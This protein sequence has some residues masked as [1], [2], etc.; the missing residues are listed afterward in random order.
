MTSDFTGR[1]SLDVD[2][3]SQLATNCLAAGDWYRAREFA[4]EGIRLSANDPLLLRTLAY[5]ECELGET[6]RAAETSA[7]ALAHEPGDVQNYIVRSHCLLAQATH[8]I[9][10]LDVHGYAMSAARITRDGL[11]LDPNNVVLRRIRAKSLA[12]GGEWR[13]AYLELH[14]VIRRSPSDLDTWRAASV[15]GIWTRNWRATIESCRRGLALS[16]N[17]P[18]LQNNLAVALRNSGQSRA[19]ADIFLEQVSR[20]PHSSVARYN[21]S[22]TGARVLYFIILLA[23]AGVFL[24]L[25]VPPTAAILPC[26]FLYGVIARSPVLLRRME[27]VTLALT[28]V[29]AKPVDRLFGR[30]RLIRRQRLLSQPIQRDVEKMFNIRHS[31]RFASLRRLGVWLLGLT[32]VAFVVSGVLVVNTGFA[33]DAETGWVFMGIGGF[34]SVITAWSIWRRLKYSR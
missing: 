20:N 11:K 17:D 8:Q 1:G 13:D 19:A 14:D 6:R 23:V 3:L 21:V 5:A 33:Q 30:R 9:K 27:P 29:I 7:R 4:R 31:R 25:R 32:S 26:A 12:L 22:L 24:A 2:T 18:P 28:K 16:P 10:E 34:F 15:V